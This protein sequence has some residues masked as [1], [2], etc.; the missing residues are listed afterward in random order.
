MDIRVDLQKGIFEPS[1]IEDAVRKGRSR[2]YLNGEDV[3][4]R[5][6]AADTVAGQVKLHILNDNGKVFV[7]QHPGPSIITYETLQGQYNRFHRDAGI[8]ARNF[9]PQFYKYHVP[10]TDLFLFRDEACIPY[11]YRTGKVTYE[12]LDESHQWLLK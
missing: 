6:V 12:F 8:E 1:W 9:W 3:S 4:S 7:Q 10:L 5:C 11:C 2:V